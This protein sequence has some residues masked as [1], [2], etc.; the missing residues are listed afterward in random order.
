[1][2]SLVHWFPQAALHKVHDI[3]LSSAPPKALESRRRSRWDVSDQ[4]EEQQEKKDP[5]NELLSAARHQA[6]AN[7]EQS[8]PPASTST[9]RTEVE[10]PEPLQDSSSGEQESDHVTCALFTQA[11]PGDQQSSDEKRDSAGE[12]EEE[13]S[14]PPMDLFKAIFAGSSDETSSSSSEGEGNDEEDAKEEEPLNLFNIASSISS[15]TVSSSTIASSQQ[16]GKKP[17]PDRIT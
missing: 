4:K 13:E 16:T 9:S 5:L 17:E 2:S 8:S 14:R 6:E 1:M 7:P 10:H 11:E 3:L 15:C 12:E